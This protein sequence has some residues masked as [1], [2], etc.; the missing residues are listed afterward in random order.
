M[1][2]SIGEILIDFVSDEIG[3]LEKVKI[4]NKYPGGAPAN[5]SVGIARLNLEITFIGMVGNDPFGEFLVSFL[6]KEGVNTKYI[7]KTE[8]NER[9]ALAFVSLDETGERSFV[10]YRNNA[11]DLKLSPEK[12]TDDIINKCEYLHF[13]TLSLSSEPSKSATIKAIT[14]CK[15][16]GAKICFDPNLRMDIWQSKE[17]LRETISHVL[18][19]VDILYP[20]YEELSF[21]LGKEVSEEE[22]INVLME[23][24]PIEIIA[25][26]KGKDGCLLKSREGFFLTIPSFEVPI[27]DTTGAGDGFNAGFIFGLSTGKTLEEAGII[28]NAI[29]ALVIQKRGAM[30]SLPTLNELKEF[31]IN[32]RVTLSI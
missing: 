11:A 23:K 31:L 6:K 12:I 19:Y 25:L 15:R 17:L 9:T 21:I 4:F 8:N 29:G 26:K 3:S 30:T 14:E 32:Q 2:I 16:N 10:F 20:S 18:P 28:G 7:E 13:G 27:I 22:A 5:F 24:Y 1:I